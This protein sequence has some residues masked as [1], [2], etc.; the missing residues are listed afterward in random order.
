MRD[1]LPSYAHGVSTTPLL[2][3]TIGDLLDDMAAAHADNEALVSVFENR[4]LTFRQFR[5]A[6]DQLGRALMALG[7]AKGDRVGI[8]STNSTGWVLVQFATA[9]IGAILVNIN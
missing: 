2:A 5:D 6:A 8:W 7:V 9:K 1:I 3:S 4:R